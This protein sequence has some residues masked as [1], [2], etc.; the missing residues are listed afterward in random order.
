MASMTAPGLT[1]RATTG[2]PWR[3]EELAHLLLDGRIEPG[4]LGRDPERGEQA[5]RDRLAVRERLVARRRL[6]RVA[7][8]V[9]QVEH[10]PLPPL[11]GVGGDDPGLVGRASGGSAR[12]G[13]RAIPRPGSHSRTSS[14]SR[15]PARRLVFTTSANPDDHSRSGSVSTVAGSHTTHSGWW[16]APTAFLAW[17]RSTAVFPPMPASTIPVSDVG[18][19][20]HGTPRR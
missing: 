20:I 16:K 2:S 12:A 10:R 8:G 5:D 15:P 6:D 18:T 13:P 14:H 9:A 1:F 19:E 4:A 7:D 3:A 11:L 17:G